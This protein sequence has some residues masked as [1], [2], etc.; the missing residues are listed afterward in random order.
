MSDVAR[1]IGEASASPS[2]HHSF[3]SPGQQQVVVRNPRERPASSL[4][5]DRLDKQGRL[6]RLLHQHR[7]LSPL[8][9]VRSTAIRTMWKIRRNIR[10]S[11]AHADDPG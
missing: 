10:R 6:T 2:Q 11:T 5:D 9:E 3:V 8:P 1:S 7:R 4:P